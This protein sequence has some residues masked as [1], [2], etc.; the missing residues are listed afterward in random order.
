[1]THAW[2]DIG[3]GKIRCDNT[4]EV[5]RLADIRSPGDASRVIRIS[6]ERWAKLERLAAFRGKTPEACVEAFIDSSQP[7]GSG[8]K[9][10][11]ATTKG[12]KT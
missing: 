6:L 11:S 8:W 4:G 1:M 7:G 9:H 12:P 2:R 5:R 10:P 3:G